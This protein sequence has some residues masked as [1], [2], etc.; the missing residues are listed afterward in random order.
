MLMDGFNSKNCFC[1]IKSR[2]MF[3]QGILSHEKGHNI[4]TREVIHNKVKVLSVL[5]RVVKLHNAVTSHFSQQVS[6][7]S[8]MFNLTEIIKKSIN[9][10][11]DHKYFLW[12][13]EN[14]SVILVKRTFITNKSAGHLI[15]KF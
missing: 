12:S 7:G 5:E 2:H 14:I 9:A 6:F 1:D 8:N 10:I 13:S 4:T 11:I 3:S 15:A